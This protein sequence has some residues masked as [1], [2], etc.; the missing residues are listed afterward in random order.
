[1]YIDELIRPAAM[2]IF[3]ELHNSPIMSRVLSY[4]SRELLLMNIIDPMFFKNDF[5]LAH[6][7]ALAFDPEILIQFRLDK[8][9]F[10]ESK[11]FAQR[12]HLLPGT[13]ASLYP[14]QGDIIDAW[15]NAINRL[16]HEKPMRHS[17]YTPTLHVYKL[18]GKGDRR[19][20]I[21][22]S[23]K[24]NAQRIAGPIVEFHKPQRDICSQM[25]RAEFV[26]SV[27]ALDTAVM[28]VDPLSAVNS[29]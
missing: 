3:F 11:T 15:A 10:I 27:A 14:A 22:A 20:L 17:T 18:T 16:P 4:D 8:P 28:E 6:M 12:V 29:K 21:D 25:T 19:A 9:V 23:K 2:S 26:A 24:A 13:V 5:R 1:L 7:I